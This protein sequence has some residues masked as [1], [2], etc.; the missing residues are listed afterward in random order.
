MSNFEGERRKQRRFEQIGTNNPRCQCG[1]TDWRCFEVTTTPS[2]AN[3]FLKF[4]I[5]ANDEQARQRRLKKLRTNSPRC[6]MCGETDWRCIEQH[7]IGGRKHDPMTVLLCANDHLRVT[8]RQIDHPIS[9]EDADE[10]LVRISNSLRGHADMHRLVAQR[11]IE[12]ADALLERA[13]MPVPPTK[14]S[15]L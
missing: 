12:F 6:A 3:C 4:T 5:D 13:Q 8:D 14:R 10:L 1:E 7:H 9:N 15:T 11:S 2:C